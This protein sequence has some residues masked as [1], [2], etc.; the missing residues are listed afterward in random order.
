MQ[1]R[2]LSWW[3]NKFQG[4]DDKHRHHLPLK[5]GLGIPICIWQ[6]KLNSLER[7]Y[8]GIA[9]IEIEEEGACPGNESLFFTYWRRNLNSPESIKYPVFWCNTV[10]VRIV[11]RCIH[12]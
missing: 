4:V 11:V 9:P 1:S 12:I 3:N 6:R 5:V 2:R 10:F 7:I 8:Y